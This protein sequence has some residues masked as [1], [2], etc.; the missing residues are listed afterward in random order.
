MTSVNKDLG[1]VVFLFPSLTHMCLMKVATALHSAYGLRKLKNVFSEMESPNSP[2][3]G[4]SIPLNDAALNK[5]IKEYLLIIPTSIRNGILETVKGIERQIKVWRDCHEEGGR[6]SYYPRCAFFWRPEGT[7][8]RT[9]TAEEIV[10]NETIDIRA[11]F[12]MACLYSLSESVQTLWQTLI[13]NNENLDADVFLPEDILNSVSNFWIP[14]LLQGA[15]CHWTEAAAGHHKYRGNKLDR[16]FLYYLQGKYGGFFKPKYNILFRELMPAERRKCFQSLYFTD[17]DDLRLCL[18]VVTKEER[19]EILKLYAEE[20]LLAYLEWPLIDIFLDQADKT[21]EFL[22]VFSFFQ[23][24][25]RLFELQS[26]A[27]VD[28]KNLAEK[29]WERSPDRFKENAE[30]KFIY[31]KRL[32]EFIEKIN[33]KNVE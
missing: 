23:V 27:D 18:Y 32:N 24:L 28:H 11:R 33:N 29:F 20:V 10:R 17:S 8:D 21:W 26:G 25:N 5:R 16:F 15:R 1:P 7:I 14:W 12:E 9:K 22:S 2:E 4:M 6:Y 19:E 3:S 30:P 13:S 31:G